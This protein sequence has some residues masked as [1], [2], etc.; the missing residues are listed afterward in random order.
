MFEGAEK[1][2][3][4]K[5]TKKGEELFRG[6][7]NDYGYIAEQCSNKYGVLIYFNRRNKT[8]SDIQP[9]KYTSSSYDITDKL[10]KSAMEYLDT[11]I[12]YCT[13]EKE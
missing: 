1:Y 8:I 6:M 2:I 10:T 9:V 5:L 11:F 7:I 4:R 12:Q 13:N 3:G